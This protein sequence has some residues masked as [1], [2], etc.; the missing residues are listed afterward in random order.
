MLD[1]D[2]ALKKEISENLRQLIKQ[3]G[4]TQIKLSEMSG[5][6]KSTL[7][8]Y[9][10][11]K[12]LINVGNVEK[13]SEALNVKKSDIDPSFKQQ[14]GNSI[15][16]TPEIL[17]IYNQLNNDNKK[18]VTDFAT[19]RL[20]EQRKVVELQTAK[21][22]SDPYR[23]LAA[24]FDGEPTDEDLKELNNFLKDYKKNKK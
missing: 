10:N 17:D 1:R 11:C 7:S 5:I 14:S 23:V 9:I 24:H 18:I 12:T 15:E 19:H 21:E 16:A 13:L 20:E 4:L 8:D 22:E 2:L 6:S 3:K